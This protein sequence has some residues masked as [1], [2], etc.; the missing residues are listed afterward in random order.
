MIYKLIL[1]GKIN[2]KKREMYRKTNH[3][4]LTDPRVVTC[5]QEL[6]LLLNRYQEI[7]RKRHLQSRTSSQNIAHP[8]VSHKVSLKQFLTFI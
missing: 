3:F 5:S 7:D 6:D 4:R 8:E 2:I 1:L